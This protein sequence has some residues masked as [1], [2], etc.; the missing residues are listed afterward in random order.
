MVPS[1]CL[2]TSHD[3]AVQH[4]SN[5]C[6]LNARLSSRSFMV[7]DDMKLK[8]LMELFDVSLHV[9]V[10]YASLYRLQRR[11]W[12][13]VHVTGWGWRGMRAFGGGGKEQGKV[14]IGKRQIVCQCQKWSCAEESA[15]AN[16]TEDGR[17][18]GLTD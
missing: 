6:L 5:L 14:L 9:T 17:K 18:Q 8:R 16:E 15:G 7:S 12:V 4:M 1:L 2:S 11:G 13:D 3:T 10:G